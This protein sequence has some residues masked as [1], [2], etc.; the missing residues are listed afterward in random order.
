MRKLIVDWN[1]NTWQAYMRWFNIQRVLIG[2]GGRMADDKILEMDSEMIGLDYVRS[3]HDFS[4]PSDPE[5][6]FYVTDEEKYTVFL[7]TY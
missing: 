3:R 7:L 5:A 2:I 1:S 6:T 4:K